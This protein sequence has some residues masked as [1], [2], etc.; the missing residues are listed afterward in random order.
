MS[1]TIGITLFSI[2]NSA[3][4]DK[5]CMKIF[6][7]IPIS[8]QTTSISIVTLTL[9]SISIVN[10]L[11]MHYY[12]VLKGFYVGDM[13]IF[14]PIFNSIFILF[15][16]AILWI[17][18][19]CFTL[20]RFETSI[21]LHF[22]ITFL[23]SFANVFYCRFFYQCITISA[24][25]QFSSI[26]DGI[27]YQSIIGGFEWTDIYYILSLTFFIAAWNRMKISKALPKVIRKRVFIFKILPIPF[28]LFTTAF[29]TYSIYHLTSPRYRNHPELFVPQIQEYL[30]N[31]FIWKSSMP[32]N[33]HF[34]SG[35]IRFL[36]NDVK[37]E[38]TS[39]ELSIKEKKM[40]EKFY[41]NHKLRKTTHE[42]NNS[43]KNVT[44]ILLE[45][46]LSSASDLYVDGKEITPFLNKLKKDSTVYYNGKIHPN[47]TIGESGDGQLIY[48]S[49]LLPIRN[50]ITVSIAKNRKLLGLPQIL[51]EKYGIKY[52]EIVIPSSPVVW[53]QRY[54]NEQYGIDYM[55]S[56]TDVET[57]STFLIN[58]EKVFNL[59]ETTHKEMKQPFF[60]MVLGVSTHQ[61]YNEPVDKSFNLG[62]SAYPDH[63][64]NYLIACH[65]VDKQIEKYV[66]FLRKKGIFDNSLIVITSDHNPHIDQLNMQNRISTNMPLYIV[67]SGLRIRDMYHGEA[68]QL[69]VY[70]TILDILGI[71]NKWLGLGHSLLSPEYNNSVTTETYELSEKMILGDYFNNYK[72]Q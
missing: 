37:D 32:V 39:Y 62:D 16:I 65:Y 23:W 13:F 25:K 28:I 22:T 33:V 71:E 58:E 35:S 4:Q 51:K 46:F 59:A 19:L 48:M 42:L 1:W 56:A 38:C 29:V 21:I 30:I 31:P 52:T 12:F 60:S 10:L 11:Y 34:I 55:F 6:D 7:H 70:T 27:V 36:I 15:D 2:S 20:F 53:E 24:I 57:I 68:N 44:F 50:K 66:N 61:P 18:L 17:I 26:F 64:K 3:Y 67:N 8:R 49:G 40:I 41:T 45:S 43:I 5:R 47:I 63:Y 9:I 69:D 14:T 72:K 54:M